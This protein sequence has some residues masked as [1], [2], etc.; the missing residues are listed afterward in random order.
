VAEAQRIL[1]ILRAAGAPEDVLAEVRR[2]L[3]LWQAGA[4]SARDVYYMIMGVCRENLVPLTPRQVS[5]LRLALGLP[6]E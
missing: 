1:D 6:P 2:I 3:G 5:E 4:L